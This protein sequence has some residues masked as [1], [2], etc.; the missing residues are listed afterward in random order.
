MII[1]V[2]NNYF[3]VADFRFS[4]QLLV[5]F[6]YPTRAVYLIAFV[7][8]VIKFGLPSGEISKSTN[9]GKSNIPPNIGEIPYVSIRNMKLLF[10]RHPKLNHG[11]L[12]SKSEQ[13]R[14][15]TCGELLTV[16]H[17]IV[18]CRNYEKQRNELHLPSRREGK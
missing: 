12:T 9:P 11:Y 6:K 5:N 3:V 16:K 1:A 4:L 14:C 18:Y 2:K 13:T 15:P 17:I 10:I 7:F 8:A